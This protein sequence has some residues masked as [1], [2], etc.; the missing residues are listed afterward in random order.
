M[1]KVPIYLCLSGLALIA[2]HWYVL[3]GA[4]SALRR[5]SQKIAQ[6]SMAR[7]RRIL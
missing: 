5:R 3:F 4:P 1:L 7:R 6:T 2:E